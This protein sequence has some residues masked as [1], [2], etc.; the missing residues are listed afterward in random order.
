[1]DQD[2]ANPAL[3]VNSLRYKVLWL[4]RTS[5]NHGL[6]WT[7]QGKDSEGAG[8]KSD[9]AS[10][11]HEGVYCLFFNSIYEKVSKISRAHRKGVKNMG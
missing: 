1:M 3:T 4:M 7:A 2:Q 11:T 8:E 9:W 6:E 10:D 5:C